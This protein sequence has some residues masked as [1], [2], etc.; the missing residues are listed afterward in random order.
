MIVYRIK[1]PRIAEGYQNHAHMGLFTGTLCNINPCH[2][3]NLYIG[4]VIFANK[5]VRIYY[6]IHEAHVNLYTNPSH[7]Q[8]NIFLDVYNILVV[9]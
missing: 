5:S 3:K 1:N 6:N 7:R 8:L 4:L 2:R 9:A